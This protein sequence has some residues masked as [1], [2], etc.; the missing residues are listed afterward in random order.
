MKQ[1]WVLDLDDTLYD[2]LDFQVSGMLSILDLIRKV[3]P[4]IAL[5]K[6]KS[7]DLTKP[8][9]IDYLVGL[10]DLNDS[11]KEE[12][13][14]VYRLHSPEIKLRKDA[15]SFIDTLIKTAHPIAILTDGR[16]VTQRNKLV[17]LGLAAIPAL[18]SSE[19]GETKPSIGR[20][21]EIQ[22]SFEA[23]QYI[24]VGDNPS[25]DFIA[26][27]RL[28]WTSFGVRDNGRHIHK[29]EV[30]KSELNQPTYWVDSLKD[31]ESFI[32]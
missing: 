31:V 10:A 17:A 20:F 1:C 2:E 28:G 6:I 4:D 8:R 24:Y 23:E 7:H 19:W 25:K 3:F 12:L 9:F 11:Q 16:S 5:D 27:N 21:L 30:E 18:I 15:K 22:K 14:W 26:P 13:L 32:C 29:Q